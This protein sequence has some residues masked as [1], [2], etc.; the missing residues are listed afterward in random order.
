MR[1]KRRFW[2][3]PTNR[4][5]T[6]SRTIKGESLTALDTEAIASQIQ[7]VRSRDV[8]RSVVEKLNLASRPEYKKA[9]KGHSFFGD[10][11]APLGLAARPDSSAEE[12]VLAK[13]NDSLS[14]SA[15]AN[16]GVIA[17]DFS[18]TDP[19]L[20]ADGAD[21]IAAE[22]IALQRAARLD[23]T[24]DPA[25]WL[26]SEIIDLRNRIRDTEAR[27]LELQKQSDTDRGDAG[28]QLVALDR[29]ATAQRDLL[30][31]YRGRYGEALTRQNAGLPSVGARVLLKASV[32]LDPAF[33]K[34]VPTT[35][36]ATV[37][38]LLLGIAFVLL[39]ELAS[40]RP[41]RRV[42]PGEPPPMIPDAVHVDGR[43][44]WADDH[45]VR[46]M[47]PADPSIAP[48]IA[49]DTERSLA[50]IASRVVAAGNG[51]VLVTHAEGSGEVGR[52]RAAVAL[53]RALARADS[54]VVLL[55]L[56]GD[57]V[58][59][60]TMGQGK[61]LP[62]FADLFAGE[63]S[64]AQVIFRDRKSR[65]HFIP[66]GRKPVDAAGLDGERLASILCALDHT[67]DHV[68]LDMRDD[69][70]GAFAPTAC[71]AM[72]SSEFFDADPRTVR[73]VERVAA[74][75]PNVPVLLLIVDPAVASDD[76]GDFTP[77]TAAVAAA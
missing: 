29:E 67:Y 77:A 21:A 45:G 48:H 66:A 42:S 7:L 55:D 54:R 40:G 34:L 10:L 5:R 49:S 19:K 1:L 74:A 26:E 38:V 56:C 69:V 39:R 51:R 64:F 75:A 41:L 16:S 73:A 28:V 23:A 30:A 53:A 43:V 72:V 24:A 36:A 68:V 65:A 14:V 60:I 70:I 71:A 13:Y 20:A 47:M 8:G 22:Y 9:I 6:Q 27:R 31:S 2:S 18:S 17:I 25:K 33:P 35:A 57:D 46:R 61:G 11:L 62:G 76:L 4:I 59:G 52:P 63:A 58:D 37:A 32:P 50:T 44:R 12:R 15:V 3:R